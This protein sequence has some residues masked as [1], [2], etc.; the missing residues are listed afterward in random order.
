MDGVDDRGSDGAA[1]D[2]AEHPGVIVDH[3]EVL[4][5]LVAGERVAKLGL[6]AADLGARRLGVDGGELGVRLRVARGE[7]RD[8]VVR[9]SEP[10]REQGNDPFDAAVTGR[11]HREPDRTQDGD[12]HA[13]SILTLP[14]STCTSQSPSNARIPVSRIDPTQDGSS[15][16]ALVAST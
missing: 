6:R 2:R 16:G 15:V 5:A 13:G 8:V 3:V 10:V 4:G 11:R 7:E 12:P 9:S 1:E 14:P